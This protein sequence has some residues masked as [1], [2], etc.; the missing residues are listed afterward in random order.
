M[1]EIER[2]TS[3]VLMSLPIEKVSFESLGIDVIA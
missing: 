2:L 1:N 3:Q